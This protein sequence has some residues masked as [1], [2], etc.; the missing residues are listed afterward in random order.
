MS[1]LSQSKEPQSKK[2]PN[3]SDKPVT[4]YQF[5]NNPAMKRAWLRNLLFG[6]AITL[7]LSLY[8]LGTELWQA[9][10]LLE[11]YGVVVV[12]CLVLLPIYAAIVRE[13][14]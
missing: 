11:I 9:K 13:L 2:P 6:F 7:P 3:A 10:N 5:A 4:R 14:S 12:T 8:G 1:D